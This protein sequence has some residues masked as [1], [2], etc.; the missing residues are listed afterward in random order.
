MKQTAVEWLVEQL[1]I[2]QGYESAIKI[3]EQAK[4]M[5]MQQ[6]IDAVKYGNSFEQGDLICEIYYKKTFKSE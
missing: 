5:E 6:I 3:L 2:S 4:E 1:D